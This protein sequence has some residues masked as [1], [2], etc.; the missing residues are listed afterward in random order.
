[1]HVSGEQIVR[2]IPKSEQLIELLKKGKQFL[3]NSFFFFFNFPYLF[4]S[5][6]QLQVITQCF[7]SGAK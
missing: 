6:T 7:L 5:K 1:M 3:K 4:R 2:C